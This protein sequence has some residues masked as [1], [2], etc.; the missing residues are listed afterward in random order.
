MSARFFVTGTDTEVG[1]TH[2]TAALAAAWR[3]AGA[4]LRAIK[5][6]ATGEPWPGGDARALSA[7]AGHPPLVHL[8]LPEPAAP[9]RAAALAGVEIHPGR[10]LDWLR[11]AMGEGPALVEGVGGWRV[12]IAPGFGVPELAQALGFPV[13]VVAANR[14]GC[15]NHTLLTVEAVQQAGLSVAGVVLNDAFGCRPALAAWNLSDLRAALG[16]LPVWPFAHGDGAAAGARV[17]S[18]L[19]ALPPEGQ[20]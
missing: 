5:P 18:A 2:V 14:L 8:C 12:P 20:R 10:L 16:E 1:K 4:D 11:G 15:I 17:L 6:L 19:G 9:A 7:A 13:L 3:A